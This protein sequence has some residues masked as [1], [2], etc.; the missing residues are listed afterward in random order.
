M[1]AHESFVTA[2]RVFPID[3][4]LGSASFVVCTSFNDAVGSLEY[5]VPNDRISNEH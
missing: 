3:S 4:R 1:I 2:H 5:I